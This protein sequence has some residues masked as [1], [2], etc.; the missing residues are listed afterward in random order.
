MASRHITYREIVS[1]VQGLN[2]F[3]DSMDNKIKSAQAN[4]NHTKER[5]LAEQKNVLAKFDA[6]C[7]NAVNAISNKSKS[8]LGDAKKI[9][10]EID[11]IDAKL[12]SIDKYY[13]K[14]K[15]KKTSE[16]AN[17]KSEKYSDVG[18]YFETLKK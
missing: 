2:S 1:L 12:S 6:D 18:D 10:T 7:Q 13:V 11:S 8:L 17:E 3:V 9:Q 4:Y 15:Q 5:M 16:L 14:T